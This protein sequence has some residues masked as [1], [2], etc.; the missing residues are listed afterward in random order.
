MHEGTLAELQ[1]ATGCTLADRDVP[2]V[3]PR[4]EQAEAAA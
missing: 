2:A 4:T 3:L 1:A